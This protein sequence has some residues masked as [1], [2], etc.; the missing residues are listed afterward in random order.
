[1]FSFLL[2]ENDYL[3]DYMASYIAIACHFRI[4]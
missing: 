2:F 3:Y 4:L 1:M